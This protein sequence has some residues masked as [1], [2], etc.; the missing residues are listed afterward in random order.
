VGPELKVVPADQESP[1]NQ[2]SSFCLLVTG[3]RLF[4]T[5]WL[6]DS[7]DLTLG[8]AETCQIRIDDPSVAPQHAV[9]HL[10]RKPAIE[11]L[12][13]SGG[14][15]VDDRRLT[16]G[17]SVLL[18]P[19]ELIT[20]GSVLLIFQKRM[21]NRPRRIWT[22]GYFETRLEEECTRAEM[23]Q[24]QFALLR[25]HCEKTL[26]QSVVEETLANILRAVD[27][28]G[29]YG[30]GEYEV[31]LTDAQPAGAELVRKR[32]ISLLGPKDRN[33]RIGAASYPKDGRSADILSDKASEALQLSPRPKDSADI[34]ASGI[35]TFSKAMQNLDELIKRVALSTINILIM[36]ETGVG[37]DVFAERI[38]RLSLRNGKPLLRLNCASLSESLLETEL[39]GHERGAFTGAV[40]AKPGLLETADGGTIFLDEIGELPIS[41]Q[42]KL[43][44]VLEERVV[45]RV[46]SVKPKSIDV[47]FVAATNRDLEYEVARGT[48]RQDLFFRL[49]GISIVIPPLRER[50]DEIGGLVQHFISESCLKTGQIPMPVPSREVLELMKRYAWPGNIRELR[51]VVERAVLLCDQGTITL[52]ELP[53]EKMSAS[54]A[55]R[56]IVS[57]VRTTTRQADQDGDESPPFEP[58]SALSGEPPDDHPYQTQEPESPLLRKRGLQI[59]HDLQ[60]EV[61]ARERK[62]IVDAL[63]ACAGN[64]TGAAKILGI[65]RRTLVNR[66]NFH[67]IPG[68]RKNRKP[69]V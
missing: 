22:H 33:L 58:P 47:R 44:R 40:Q 46:G 64:Q 16:P 49:N 5:H 21:N 1:E 35:F 48:F 69:A 11:D 50:A 37:K 6:A 65:S 2:G 61:L 39:F 17:E 14:T 8:S 15:V 13:G 30:P 45:L 66:L 68:P 43:L 10:G 20:L 34:A 4:S 12:K 52:A 26:P 23:Y 55:P 67:S 19:G 32:I 31:L 54:F 28:V 36:G 63:S 9:L 25:I 57:P 51:N 3:E 38:H 62:Q 41:T 7:G 27:I 53:V 60:R 24:K 42:V 18:T 56:R 59:P 29:S